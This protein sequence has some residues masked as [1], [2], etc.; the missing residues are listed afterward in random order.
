MNKIIADLRLPIPDPSSQPVRLGHAWIRVN[1]P[2]AP[3]AS[4]GRQPLRIVDRSVLLLQHSI[5]LI[6]RN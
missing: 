4:N 1:D 6:A 3:F 5:V 2:S